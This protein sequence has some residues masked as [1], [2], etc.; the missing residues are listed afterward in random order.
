MDETETSRATACSPA[1]GGCAGATLVPVAGTVAP[2]VGTVAPVVGTVDSLPVIMACPSKEKGC[3]SLGEG[4]ELAEDTLPP[5][6]KRGLST[7]PLAWPPPRRCGVG[8]CDMELPPAAV[9]AA[10]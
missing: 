7:A 9:A 5:S 8:C 6:L 1:A 4:E 2:V 3:V 10:G